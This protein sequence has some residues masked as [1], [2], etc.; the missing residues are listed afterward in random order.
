MLKNINGMWKVSPIPSDMNEGSSPHGAYFPG[1]KDRVL[2][3][4]V[5]EKHMAIVVT[6]PFASAPIMKTYRELVLKGG[7]KVLFN[8]SEPS[9][10]LV[11]LDVI[12]VFARDDSF[13]MQ[14]DYYWSDGDPVA[15]TATTK[16]SINMTPEDVENCINAR[17]KLPLAKSGST[18][19]PWAPYWRCVPDNQV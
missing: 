10:K 16:I 6:I 17:H 8:V 2:A 3:G 1:P 15:Q 13:V 18:D 12:K 4:Y 19:G 14:H 11:L 7:E 5:E 9:A